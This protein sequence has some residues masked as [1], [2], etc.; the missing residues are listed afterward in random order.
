MC[1]YYKD[2]RELIGHGEADGASEKT[3]E[4]REVSQ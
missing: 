2:K 4:A 3:S 1:S